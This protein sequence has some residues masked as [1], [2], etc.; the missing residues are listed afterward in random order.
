MPEVLEVRN[1]CDLIR[2]YFLHKYIAEINIL[3]GRYKTHKPFAGYTKLRNLLKSN[4]LQITQV[5]SKGKLIYIIL[6]NKLVLL[7][8]LGLSGGWICRD[9][10]SKFIYARHEKYLTSLSSGSGSSSSSGLA[11]LDNYNKTILNHLNIE[12]KFKNHTKILYFFDMLSFGTI[13]ILFDITLLDTKLK[14]IGYDIMDA[15]TSLEIFKRELLR[16][17]NNMIGQVLVNQKLI[18]GVGNYLRA[19]SLWMAK[20]SPYRL[21]KNITNREFTKLYQSLRNLTI[22]LYEPQS[23]SDSD[24]L[25]LPHNYNRIFFA[26]REDSDIY[27][28]KITKVKFIDGRYIYYA[29]KRQ[30]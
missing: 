26:Y 30:L 29:K 4:Y 27:G 13:K 12:F 15:D 23:K 16:Q 18:S 1:Y 8:T 28:N 2:K 9:S 19:D 5:S 14:Q 7:C 21:V 10:S 6:N 20:I 24:K 22:G 25:F 17:P 11:D 3:N